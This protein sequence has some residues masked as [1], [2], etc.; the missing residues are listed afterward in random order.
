MPSAADHRST[1]PAT[2]AFPTD[3]GDH[4]I[5]RFGGKFLER[6][7][8]APPARQPASAGETQSG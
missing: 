7:V 2:T 3:I 5:R 4:L 1:S 6:Y 8:D